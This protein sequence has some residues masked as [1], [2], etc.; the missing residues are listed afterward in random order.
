MK[1]W[2]IRPHVKI[3]EFHTLSNSCCNFVSCTTGFLLILLI[4]IK[5]EGGGKVTRFPMVRL[6]VD[7]KAGGAGI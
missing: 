4:K 1:Y 6:K 3:R 7:F 2:T 5:T